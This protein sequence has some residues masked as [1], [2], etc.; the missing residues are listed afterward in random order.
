MKKRF[1]SFLALLLCV[2]LLLVSCNDDNQTGTP[3]EKNTDMTTDMPTDIP[4]DTPTSDV[5]N[6]STPSSS[7]QAAPLD[8][9]P[10]A[11]IGTYTIH[12]YLKDGGAYVSHIEFS[13][14][15]KNL[16]VE[17]PATV[18]YDVS[19]RVPIGTP[20]VGIAPRYFSCQNVPD[21]Y[22]YDSLFVEH[23]QKPL[24][25]AV[26]EGKISEW[27]YTNFLYHYIFRSLSTCHTQKQKDELLQKYPFIT[28]TDIWEFYG[29]G[30]QEDDLDMRVYLSFYLSEYASYT[31]EDYAADQEVMKDLVAIFSNTDPIR[32]LILP[33]SITELQEGTFAGLC[34]LEKVTL[35]QNLKSIG[36]YAFAACPKL[37]EITI[38][39]K[40]TSIG[41]SAFQY[42]KDLTK[43]S[44]PQELKSIADLTFALCASLTDI[45]IPVSVTSIG[46][47][48]FEDCKSLTNLTL[49][50][51]LVDIG[52]AAFL[53]CDNLLYTIHESGKY[54]GS[55][56]NPYMI[57]VGFAESSETTVRLHDN[58]KFFYNAPFKYYTTMESIVIPNGVSSIGD[59][60]FI[61]CR[62]LTE[63]MIPVSVTSIGEEA[64]EYCR[65][66][67][68]IYYKGSETEWAVISGLDTCSL[69][70]DVQIIY[71]YEGSL[72]T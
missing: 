50:D 9:S 36:A 33:D 25:Q 3:T 28:E 21:C 47:G 54:L 8:P 67:S 7:D 32:E 52:S 61:G 24:E 2:S 48:A 64:F 34:N 35:P 72:I 49:P 5:S 15:A 45:T 29:F 30:S 27:E 59:S 65:S 10:D 62:N 19:E 51:E 1:C 6:S 55:T 42:C 68:V 31:A 41:E 12:Y 4:T 56:K 11:P 66:L 40:V 38:P 18:E 37:T 26:A 58:V 22:I 13:E 39:D 46:D 71:N 53:N 69:P 60:E 63:I 44:L 43:V 70:K 20:V 17:I 16:T 14:G 23:I 57:L